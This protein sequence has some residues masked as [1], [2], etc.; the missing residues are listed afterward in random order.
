PPSRPRPPA[1]SPPAVRPARFA[2][3]GEPPAPAELPVRRTRA[4]EYERHLERATA[5]G[6]VRRVPKASLPPDTGRGVQPA[7]APAEPAPAAGRLPEEV[8]SL[9]SS[10]RS[11]VRRGRSDDTADDLPTSQEGS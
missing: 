3:S 9:L 7:P 5:A 2:A 10:Y 11:G 4:D 8:R 1:G 6:L